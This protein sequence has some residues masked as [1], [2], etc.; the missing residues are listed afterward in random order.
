MQDLGNLEL[1]VLRLPALV[2]SPLSVNALREDLRLSHKTV[3]KW[4][5][6][7]ERL[8]A[9]FRLPPF[10]APGIRAV[11]KARKHYHWDWSLIPDQA[12]RFENLVACQLLKY[13]HFL[14]DTQGHAMELRYLRDTDRRAVD[15]VVLR[16]GKP[17][18]AVECKL[19]AEP[20]GHQADYFRQRTEIPLFFQVHCGTRDFGR[21][22]TATRVLP[23]TNFC[24]HL[25]LP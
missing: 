7:L 1:L 14:E 15:F 19:R 5:E 18:Y 23:F 10:G 21:S 8:Y 16:D 20:A 11:K 24:N 9:V 12:A 25:N 22:E 2:G 17:E 13:C 6:M 3:D 4:I